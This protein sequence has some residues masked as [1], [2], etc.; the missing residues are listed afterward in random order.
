L[1]NLKVVNKD[2]TKEEFEDD[3][4]YDSVYYPARE[5]ELS[6]EKANELAEKA[7]WEVKSWMSE[8]EDNVFTTEEI[9]DKVRDVLKQEDCDICFLYKTHMDIS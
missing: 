9:R 5:S 2:G 3:K 1:E 7:V 8:H 6:E 4:L